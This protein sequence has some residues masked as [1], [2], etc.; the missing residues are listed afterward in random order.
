[1][2]TPKPA[3]GCRG[4]IQVPRG[5]IVS[6]R[7]RAVRAAINEAAQI[8]GRAIPKNISLRMDGFIII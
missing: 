8:E 5:E 7:R 1:V 6:W 2:R 4:L 3:I